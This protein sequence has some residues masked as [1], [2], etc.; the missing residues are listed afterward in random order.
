MSNWV[1]TT[2]SLGPVTR[3]PDIH[4]TVW[5]GVIVTGG[6][7]RVHVVVSGIGYDLSRDLAVSPR[8]WAVSPVSATPVPN[9]T[10]IALRDPPLSDSDAQGESKLTMQF[11][12]DPETVSDPGPNDGLKY[13]VNFVE[14]VHD[15]EWEITP[16]IEN[17]LSAYYGAQ[18]GNYNKD[19][20]PTG[21]IS[22]A[23]LRNNIIEHESG[24]T[25]GHYAQYQAA[26]LSD[27]THNPGTLAELQV[28][29]VSTDESSFW[30]LAMTAVNARRD[31]IL[32]AMS[33]E[34]ACNSSIKYDTSCTFRGAINYLP[35]QGC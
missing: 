24:V 10:F 5:T 28:G 2:L 30:A 17:A 26:I 20:N 35:Y 32:T 8:N 9:G 29:A 14:T 27:P 7:G 34:A 11:D 15:F 4:S 1:Y 3:D 25:L 13:T 19:T 12:F 23:V 18:C 21:F 6:T 33:S 31:A 16:A 22:A